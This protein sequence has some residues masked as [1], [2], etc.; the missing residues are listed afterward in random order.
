[1]NNLINNLLINIS[2]VSI[3]LNK[4]LEPNKSILLLKDIFKKYKYPTINDIL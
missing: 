3:F 1:M 2:K 4:I